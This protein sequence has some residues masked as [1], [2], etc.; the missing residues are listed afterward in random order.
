MMPRLDSVWPIR[1]VSFMRRKWQAMEIS[2]PPP[3]SWPLM[4]AMIGLEALDLAHYAVAEA[5]EGLDVAA[6]ERRA[7]VGAAAEDLVARA[8]DD[9]GAHAVVVAHRV[10]RVVQLADERLADGVGGWAVERDDRV[11]LLALQNERLKSHRG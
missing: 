9:D 1:A 11:R 3:I 7:E 8:R 6:G 4:A 10:Q 2:M 5:D